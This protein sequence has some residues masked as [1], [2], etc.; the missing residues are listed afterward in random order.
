MADFGVCENEDCGLSYNRPALKALFERIVV[1]ED[2][3]RRHADVMD[4]LPYLK[5]FEVFFQVQQTCSKCGKP[6]YRVTQ[7]TAGLPA[8]SRE[9]NR[10]TQL[11][12]LLGAGYKLHAR[13]VLPME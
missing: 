1:V 2:R 5:H 8:G 9:Y 11:N 6:L 13:G 4:M 7:P 3:E 12:D 10:R